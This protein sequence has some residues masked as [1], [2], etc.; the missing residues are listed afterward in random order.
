[1]PKP[2][3]DWPSLVIAIEHE[4]PVDL[5]QLTAALGAVSDE[6]ERH[7]RRELPQTEPRETRLLITEVRK[8]STIIELVPQLAWVQ[9]FIPSY[10]KVA[11]TAGFVRN[12][13]D[14][15]SPYFKRGNR[16]PSLP[17]S[18][19]KNLHDLAAI[20]AQDP[21]GSI[22]FTART[23]KPD[24]SVEQ[25][26]YTKNDAREALQ[27][28]DAERAERE[29]KDS[30]E[31]EK[32]LLVFRQTRAAD[33]AMGKATGDMGIIESIDAR[34]RRVVYVSKLAG[35]KIKDDIQTAGLNPYHRGYIVDVNVGTSG[36]RPQ[37]YR[38]MALHEIIDIDDD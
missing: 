9:P 26:R 18:T 1:M 35:D 29:R 28:L 34:P 21:S 14:L 24:G 13:K 10:E 27:N 5:N 7:I 11:L 22:S 16:T 6:Y 4:D 8:G 19:V 31:H 20:I 37:V 12:V 25:F 17:A 38:V 30:A 36:G 3:S 15:L 32:V 23:D 33:A 2:P